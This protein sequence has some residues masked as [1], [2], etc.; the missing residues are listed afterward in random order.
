[1]RLGSSI[2]RR[3]Y[4][5][6]G[7]FTWPKKDRW[8]A[9]GG[10]RLRSAHGAV[11]FAVLLASFGIGYSIATRLLFPLPRPRAISLKFPTSAVSTARKRAA[12]SRR[13]G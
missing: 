1:M 4:R 10:V 3:Q 12:F 9:L 5:S 8:L 11:A 13:Q 7:R 6:D 2:R